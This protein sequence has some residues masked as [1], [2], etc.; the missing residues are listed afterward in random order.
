MTRKPTE[1]GE[2]YLAFVE[3]HNLQMAVEDIHKLK[4]AVQ[5]YERA[6]QLDPKFVLAIANLSILH[7]WI[8]HSYEPNQTEHDAAQHYSESAFQLQPSAPETHLARGYFLYYGER[9]FDHALREFAIAQQGLPN[10]AQ[11]YLIIGAIQRRQGL[12]KESTANLEKAVSLNPNDTWPLQNLFF[13]YQMQRE[14][15]AA[16]RTIDRA[17]AIDPKSFSL[18]GLKARLA[19]LAR[20]DFNVAEEGFAALKEGNE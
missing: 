4:Q 6:I 12:W 9:D 13:N 2:A 3:A 17:L 11:T 8:Y 16:N 20:G 5:L 1:N 14:F 7:S 10:D 15:E 18:R 19:V